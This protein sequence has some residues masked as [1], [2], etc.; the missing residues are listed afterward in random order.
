M[1]HSS[2]IS[3]VLTDDNSTMTIEDDT[4]KI[5]LLS[6]D[7]GLEP[8]KDHFIYRSKRYLDQKKLIEKYEGSLEEF[9][10]GVSLH[11]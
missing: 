3:A 11:Q 4:E 1:D 2:I 7:P 6:I 5:G 8:F 10:Q 9:A